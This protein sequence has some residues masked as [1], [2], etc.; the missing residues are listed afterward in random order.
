MKLAIFAD[1]HGNLP[2]LK[3]IL[4]DIKAKEVDEIISL[5]DIV[6]IGPNPAECLDLIKKENVTALIGN[7]EVECLTSWHKQRR[8]DYSEYFKWQ[9][10][11][12]SDENFEYMRSQKASVVRNGVI[13][14]HFI[15]DGV[16]EENYP[17]FCYVNE[18]VEDA[19]NL[20]NFVKEMQFKNIFIGHEHH[21]VTKIY[22]D[23]NVFCIG[24]SGCL[25][26]NNTFYKILDISEDGKIL[27]I[28]NQNVEYDRQELINNFN[29]ADYPNRKLFADI[30][31]GIEL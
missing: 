3:A 20:L 29:A 28:K 25:T 16:V 7:H 6:S 1:I 2:A 23:K 9:C 15:I 31:Y 4:D 5:G 24:S 22:G 27:S 12:L 18:L 14:Q 11:I 26:G 19:P 13:F 17:D 10:S 21:A 8:Y 30:F